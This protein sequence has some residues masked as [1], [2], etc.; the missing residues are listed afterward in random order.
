MGK[1]EGLGV[2][3]VCPG[4]VGDNNGVTLRPLCSAKWERWQRRCSAAQG[5]CSVTMGH[6]V[7]GHG[8]GVHE[9]RPPVL[10]V[11]T[12]HAQALGRAMRAGLGQGMQ[13]RTCCVRSGGMGC[14]GVR[15]ASLTPS[16]T[17]ILTENRLRDRGAAAVSESLK[18][19]SVLTSLNLESM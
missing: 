11:G 18:V 7:R 1:A 17:P 3:G 5:H 2:W 14:C 6:G 9:G 13:C 8:G 12:A 4:D 19:N 16:L 10:V 15:C